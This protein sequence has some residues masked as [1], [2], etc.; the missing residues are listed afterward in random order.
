MDELEPTGGP[1]S[2]AQRYPHQARD[3]ALVEAARSGDQHAFGKLYDAWFDRVFDLSRRIVRDD[4]TAAEVAQEAFLAAWR[5][6]DR[7]ADPQAFG[8]WLLRIARNASFNRQRKEQRSAPVD[9]ESLAMIE[10]SGGTG[11]GGP[12][13]FTVGDRFST[14]DDPARAVEDRELAELLWNAADALGERDAQVLDLSLRHGMSPAE[15][16]DVMGMNRNAANQL[17]HRVRGR[18]DTAVSAR[19]LWGNGSPACAELAALLQAEGIEH[20]DGDAVRVI[21]KHAER[22]GRCDERRRSRLAPS[23][24]FASI[25]IAAPIV[26]KQKVAFALAGAGVP[27]NGSTMLGSAL[28]LHPPANGEAGPDASEALARATRGSVRRRVLAATAAALIVVL[29]TVFAAS[30]GGDE[31]A[32]ELATDAES[33]TTTSGPNTTTAPASPATTG[34]I[35]QPSMTLI[36]PS[37]T[38]STT[39]ST[40]STTTTSALTTTPPTTTPVQIRLEVRPARI[41]TPYDLGGNPPAAPRL[42]WSAV[43]GDSVRVWGPGAGKPD[44]FSSTARDGSSYLCPEVPDGTLCAAEPGS[45]EY[46][47][48]VR[49][50]DGTVLASDSVTLTILLPPIP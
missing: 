31:P 41:E 15:I 42:A 43:G 9:E 14:I 37:T 19:V 40:L 13:G 16:G 29:V 4:D 7:L 50:A 36:A 8:G 27:M 34:S 39:T 11:A 33:T 22:C 17:V 10:R 44:G 49:G 48:E 18:L 2:G 45:Y 6:L 30:R 1:A 47:I 38:A 20:F 46:R 35:P 25:P 21:D 12:A 24:M 3:A 26:L 28:P 23:A 5:N 32:S